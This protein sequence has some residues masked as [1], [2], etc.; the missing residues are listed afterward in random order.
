[1]GFGESPIW[2]WKKE[3]VPDSAPSAQNTARGPVI[4]IRAQTGNEWLE[5]S[6]RAE[7]RIP[8]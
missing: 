2:D 7:W 4:R 8:G 1:M 3:P 5:S 6:I